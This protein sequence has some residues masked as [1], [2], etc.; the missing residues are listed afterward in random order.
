MSGDQVDTDVAVVGG[1]PAGLAAA[2]AI[3]RSGASVTVLEREEG[4]GGVARHV[5]HSGYGLREFRRLLRG[6]EYA[7]R[8]GERAARAGVD[9]R[10]CTTATAWAE[11]EADTRSLMLTSPA[12]RDSLVARAVVL[13]TGTRERPRSA[14]LVPGSRPS[15]V[16]TTGSLQRIVASG[17]RPGSLAVIVGAEHVSFSALMT[18]AHAGCRTV[19]IVTPERRH[20]SY[21]LLRLMSASRHRV[22]VLTRT[23]IAAIRGRDR[24]ESIELFDH[25]S[26][27][28]R[29]VACDTVVFTGDWI[30]DHELARRGSVPIDPGTLG[31]QVDGA[32]RTGTRGVFGAGNLLHGAETAGVCAASGTWVARA[33]VAWL[34]DPDPNRWATSRA[35]P[36]EC[37][38][39][40]RWISPNLLVPGET[41]I[42]HGRFLARSTAIS[43]RPTVVVRQG[44]R[45][46]WRGRLR[47]TV[48]TMPIHLP[49]DWISKV[50]QGEPVRIAMT[51]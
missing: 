47:R 26:G 45:E 13:A 12:G 6:P 33:V 27:Q 24:V 32:L 14:R 3:R 18:L 28:T 50:E 44:E 30:P 1:G 10:T 25:D 4:V 37:E 38:T 40:L 36:I 5:A 17:R 16:L 11:D 7:R 23:T 20:Q 8:W 22:P 9:V 41:G 51:G 48:P 31:P 35:V 29:V 19:A 42:P 2:V 39:P 49:D 15:G 46:L 34:D 21:A 43:R